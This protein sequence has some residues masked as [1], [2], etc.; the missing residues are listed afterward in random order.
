MGAMD[1]GVYPV[2]VRFP[3]AACA[4]PIMAGREE[5]VFDPMNPRQTR[6]GYA[7]YEDLYAACQSGRLSDRACESLRMGDTFDLALVL[8]MVVIHHEGN[9]QTYDVRAV[10]WEHMV[11]KGLADIAYHYVIHPDGTIYEGRS[12]EVRGAHVTEANTGKLGVLLLGDFQPGMVFSWGSIPWDP[13]DDPGPTSAQIAS[14]MDL[15]RWLDYLYGIDFVK[16]HRDV[17]PSDVCPGDK[18]TE[19][20][21]NDFQE[22]AQ[23]R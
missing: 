8:N 14:T 11:V 20:L 1:P 9:W 15:I 3:T 17:D 5:G 21:M 23:E 7:R 13:D 16:G 6:G 19:E 2:Q 12:I 4:I 10:Q 22:V 18:L